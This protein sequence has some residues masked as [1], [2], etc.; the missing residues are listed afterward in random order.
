MT[1][2]A[3]RTETSAVNANDATLTGLT[4]TQPGST[5]ADTAPTPPLT[6]LRSG[7]HRRRGQ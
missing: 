1:G 5:V 6:R 4:A 7:H 3:A 2:P